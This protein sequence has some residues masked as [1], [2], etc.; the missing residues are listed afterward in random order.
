MHVFSTGMERFTPDENIWNYA[1]A[2]RFVIVTADADFVHLSKKRGSTGELQLQNGPCRGTSA[3]ER[4]S[5]YRIGA[6][7][8]GAPDYSKHNLNLSPGEPYRSTDQV[9]L[10]KERLSFISH[11]ERA[12]RMRIIGARPASRTERKQ[13]E[14]GIEPKTS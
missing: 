8:P 12:G 14:E 6:V 5:N 7:R 4:H 11:S 10:I 1:A 13:Y 3:I 2:N 9:I